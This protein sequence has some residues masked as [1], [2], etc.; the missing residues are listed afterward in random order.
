MSS[1][2]QP[3]YVPSHPHRPTG[4]ISVN[5]AARQL[6]F[7]H[8]QGTFGP[9]PIAIGKPE[10]PTPPGHFVVLGK[11][12]NPGGVLGSRWITFYGEYGI[13]GTNQPDSIGKAVSH[14]C[15]RL[16]NKDIESFFPLVANRMP[17]III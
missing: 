12:M 13:H 6:T 17:V 2:V 5:L 4:E 9:F 14:G 15:I 8:P 16:H 7:F 11:G 10:T 1:S 3:E